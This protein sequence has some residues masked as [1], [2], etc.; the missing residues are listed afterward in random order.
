MRTVLALLVAALG[1]RALLLVVTVRGE[2]MRP[3]YA[4][5]DRLLAVRSPVLRRGRAIVFTPPDDVPAPGDP[6]YRVKRLVAVAGD[7]TP[8]W[9]AGAVPNAPVPPGH[10]VVRGDAN[11]SDDSRRY[12]YVPR[13]QVH[14][15]V[16]R[17]LQ[18]TSTG[19]VST[20]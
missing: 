9:V 18:L 16:V 7:P 15:V 3:T 20:P 10:L 4:D 12:G 1:V 19:N 2:S 5:G 17:R 11:L 13:D 8:A 6:V 14:A